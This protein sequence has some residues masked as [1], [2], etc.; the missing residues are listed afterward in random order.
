MSLI[1]SC[2]PL[3]TKG[4]LSDDDPRNAI[5]QDCPRCLGIIVDFPAM[6]R[7]DNKTNICSKC[8]QQEAMEDYFLGGCKPVSQWPENSNTGSMY[9]KLDRIGNYF[10]SR[11]KTIKEKKEDNNE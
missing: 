5:G 4:M 11:V 8:G 3:G 9:P 10:I 7:A 6:S 1:E 2:Q